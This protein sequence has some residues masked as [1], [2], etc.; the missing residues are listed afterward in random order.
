MLEPGWAVLVISLASDSDRRASLLP[1]LSRLGLTAHVIEGV[2]GRAGLPHWAEAQ[3]NRAAAAARVG[4]PLTDGEL[5]CTLS[6]RRAW[7]HVCETGAPGALIFEDDAIPTDRLAGLLA[8]GGHRAADLVQFDHQDARIWRAW[9]RAAP[10]R[11]LGHGLRL[12]AVASNASLAIGYAVSA[13]GAAHLLA[14]A[15]PVSGLADWPCDTTA[16]GAMIALAQRGASSPYRPD[17][18][19]SRSHA[20][21]LGRG[22]PCGRW[23]LAPPPERRVLATLVVQATHP[24]D[25]LTAAPLLPLAPEPPHVQPARPL[26]SPPPCNSGHSP[27]PTTRPHGLALDRKCRPHPQTAPRRAALAL[28]HCGDPQFQ[29]GGI[30]GRD[31]ALGPVAELSGAGLPRDGW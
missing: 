24:Q 16:L 28:H 27:A 8:A 29:S 5:A 1:T 17:S 18:V 14:A 6:H 21:R 11:D 30:S 9:A 25:L 15:T 12:V 20:P 26:S 22:V 7:Q 10:A 4:R 2:D 3:V 19:A 13:R 31:A 23:P